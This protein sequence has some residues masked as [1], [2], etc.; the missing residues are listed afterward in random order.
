MN[1][2]INEER[3]H[4]KKRMRNLNS[5]SQLPS[6]SK[7][8]DSGFLDGTLKAQAI[9][10]KKRYIRL[11]QIKNFCEHHQGRRQGTEWEDYLQIIY[12]MRTLVFR[13]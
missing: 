13:K 4:S 11:H 2:Y 3:P 1:D 8:P 6:P 12:L 7:G 9:K 10:E 5:Q